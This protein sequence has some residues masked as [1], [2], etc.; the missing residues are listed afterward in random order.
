MFVGLIVLALVASNLFTSWHLYH[1]Q[2]TTRV[3]QMEIAMLRRELRFLDTSD[4]ENV[5][6]IA[7]ETHQELTWKW[8]IF[9][10]QGKTQAL[11]SVVGELPQGDFPETSRL[12][13][14][15]PGER[16]L[17]CYVSR[18]ANG[19]WM[20][21]IRT[22]VDGMVSDSR[23]KIPDEQMAW[24]TQQGATHTSGVLP[25]T[26]HQQTISGTDK[27]G[28]IWYRRYVGTK[29]N[30]RV[31]TTQPS[32]GIVFWLEPFEEASPRKAE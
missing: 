25:V 16:E 15:H 24:V 18:S 7:L 17:T 14:L 8:R 4:Q 23:S 13:W 3:Q 28:L 29:P 2:Q 19:E 12:M 30:Q 5:H 27:F 21:T 6:I 11:K 26:K 9:I 32:E 10:P 22:E 20:Q 31:D 1:A